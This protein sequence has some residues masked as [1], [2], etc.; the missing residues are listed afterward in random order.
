MISGVKHTNDDMLYTVFKSHKCPD[1]NGKV[2][3]VKTTAIVNAK[4]FE[5]KKYDIDPYTIGD[6]KIIT[7]EFYCAKCDKK[8]SIEDMKRHEGIL[9]KKEV[10]IDGEIETQK[11][12]K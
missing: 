6:V 8:I 12:E 10:V 2:K 1:C 3:R 11:I 5:A 7:V 9:P 4:S